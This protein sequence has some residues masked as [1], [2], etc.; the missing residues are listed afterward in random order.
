MHLVAIL[1]VV[2]I[3]VCLPGTPVRAQNSPGLGVQV[4]AL[5]SSGWTIRETD[6]VEKRT[7]DVHLSS[8]GGLGL[9]ISYDFSRLIAGYA[10]VD[11]SA[12]Q[13]GVYG[14]YSAGVILQATGNGA[15]RFHARAGGRVINVVAPL[16]YAELGLGAGVFL[17]PKVALG[18]DAGA[19]IPL[20][21][22]S[23][24]TG[25]H[26]IEV[27]PQGGP[28]RVTLGLAWYPR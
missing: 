2:G 10:G 25:T 12:E 14:S 7:T 3:A 27:S 4:H 21:N 24:Y 5:A 16:G 28:K 11:L 13:E 17:S 15:L 18:V 22:G 8:G 6:R 26:T 23:R 9:R 1:G 20:G 19:A